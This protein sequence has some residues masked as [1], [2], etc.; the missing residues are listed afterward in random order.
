[1]YIIHVFAQFQEKLK[2][3]A[4][5]KDSRIGAPIEKERQREITGLV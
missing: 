2:L 1:M 4:F 5:K 3:I